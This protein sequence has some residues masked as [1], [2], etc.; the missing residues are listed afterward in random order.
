MVVTINGISPVDLPE[1]QKLGGRRTTVHPVAHNDNGEAVALG[2][3]VETL[4]D[5]SVASG[6]IS[7]EEASGLLELQKA[8]ATFT[9]C[10]VPELGKLK[11]D[12]GG[13]DYE[14][15]LLEAMGCWQEIE[16]FVRRV[17]Q[18][19]QTAA[20]LLISCQEV[21]YTEIGK[22][23]RKRQK[24]ASRATR[25]RDGYEAVKQIALCVGD[26]RAV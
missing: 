2:R 8:Y 6:L 17:P 12:G 7:R 10:K 26:V 18:M 19:Y 9:R 11:V 3:K 20:L 24:A 23:A 1:A 16:K 15:V 4:L 14:R 13:G 22:A 21:S 25:L 5:K